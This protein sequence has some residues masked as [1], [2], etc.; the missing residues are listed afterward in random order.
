MTPT[1]RQFVLAAATLAC[2]CAQGA[3][4]QSVP[5]RA[6][7]WVEASETKINGNAAPT[8]LDI[9]GAMDESTR[10][11]IKQ[12]MRKYGLPAGWSPSLSCVTAQELNVQQWVK[13]TASNCGNLSVKQAG[14]KFTFS[15]T[16]AMGGQTAN[17]K[18]SAQFN[19]DKEVVQE[20]QVQTT[21]QGK[22]VV[23]EN[24]SVAKWVGADCNNP[25]AGIDPAWL[26]DM[27]AANP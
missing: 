7:L 10:N 3:L 24:R 16:C 18:G 19:G 4:A 5:S 20:A 17:V 2:L 23:S 8:M 27:A 22:P 12:A 6:G 1:P 13:K 15:G 21:Y 14:N 11:G 9:N 25:P 26:G